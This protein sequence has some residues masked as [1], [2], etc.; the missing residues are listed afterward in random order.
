VIWRGAE[1]CE[2][3]QEPL[4]ACVAA[5]FA[6]SPQHLGGCTSAVGPGHV[7]LLVVP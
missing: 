1:R 4:G 3:S 7:Q 5:P 6:V 2:G